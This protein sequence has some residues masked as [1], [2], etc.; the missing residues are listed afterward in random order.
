MATMPESPKGQF[1]GQRAE[2]WGDGRRES[3][4]RTEG[5]R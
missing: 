4:D 2:R 3:S 1:R 5:G